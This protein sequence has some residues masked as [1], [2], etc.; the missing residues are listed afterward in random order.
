MTPVRPKTCRVGIEYDVP[1]ISALRAPAAL[2]PETDR[3]TQ[4]WLLRVSIST[5][6]SSVRTWVHTMV[7]EEA[8]RR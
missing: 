6:V 4:N 5:C 1:K 7:G 3:H 2:N 8:L